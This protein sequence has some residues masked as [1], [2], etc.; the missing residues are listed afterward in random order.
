[1]G[2]FLIIDSQDVGDFQWIVLLECMF[3]TAILVDPELVDNILKVCC[4][5]TV[6][7]AKRDGFNHE[8]AE[9]ETHSFVEVNCR[10]SEIVNSV[11]KFLI[12]VRI[13]YLCA[14]SD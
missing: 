10:P 14:L 3:Q 12:H 9:A 8:D 6:M 4:I 5:S 2:F 11:L 7:F 1:M 13:F